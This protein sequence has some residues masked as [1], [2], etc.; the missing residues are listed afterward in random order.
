[1]SWLN[2]ILKQLAAVLV[3]WWYNWSLEQAVHLL[4]HPLDGARPYANYQLVPLYS[5]F[6]DAANS[7]KFQPTLGK[8][9]EA[10][11]LNYVTPEADPDNCQDYLFWNAAHPSSVMEK[12]IADKFLHFVEHPPHPSASQTYGLA[13]IPRGKPLTKQQFIHFLKSRLA[14][15]SFAHP[16]LFQART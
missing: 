8:A 6:E 4:N 2:I 14:G 13:S 7:Y 10:S 1:M 15:Q 12:I 9:C 5:W 16:P 3:T 11:S